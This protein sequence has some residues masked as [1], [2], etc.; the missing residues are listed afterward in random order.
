MSL[1]LVAYLGLLRGMIV[2]DAALFDIPL[3]QEIMPQQYSRPK[4]IRL[5]NINDV[6]A[7]KMTHFNYSQLR[8]LYNH[9]G[10]VGLVDDLLD[11]TIPIPT[12][13]E[14]QRGVQ[15]FYR[16]HPEELFLFTMTKLRSAGLSPP[17]V[18]A[19]NPSPAVSQ[20]LDISERA[21]QR[22]TDSQDA[23]THDWEVQECAGRSEW[24]SRTT[25][26]D[27]SR[28]KSLELTFI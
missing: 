9:F 27:E 26:G 25:R 2:Y 28:N 7:L 5:A 12:G 8:Q 11:N 1:T 24:E 16:V 22:R 19:C 20:V 14:N 10:F 23:A 4:N 15:C 6:Q 21:Q 3:H 18:V 13:Q 17:V